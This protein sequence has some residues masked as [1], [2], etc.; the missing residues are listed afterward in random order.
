MR[1]RTLIGLAG[2]AAFAA[3]AI[4]GSATIKPSAASVKTYVLVH[5]AWHGGWC[6]RK[7]KQHLE[8]EGHRVFTPTLSGLGERVHLMSDE[9]GL[10]TH[11]LDVVNHILYE[12]LTD[13]I[14]VG[15]SYGGMVI[16]G[17]V[18]Q[19]KDRISQMVYL[20]AAVPEDGD[21]F[22]SQSPGS[23]TES[24][25]FTENQFR[26]LSEDGTA[27]AVFPA[28]VFGIAASDERNIEWVEKHL[29]PHPLKTWLDHISLQ[30]N[31]SYGVARTYIHCV[32]PI[33][34]NSSFGS[35]YELLSKD[36]SWATFVIQTGHDAMVTAPGR[37]SAMLLA[38]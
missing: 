8:K 29:T 33:L 24:V 30:N 22:A 17:V 6:W 7:V 23:T 20:D 25:E 26:S 38:V 2:A 35:H 19:L 28:S 31:G 5:G 14:L 21:N 15:H 11:I 12:E 37:L 3:P 10:E 9:I 36:E 4:S 16:T 13:I 32:Q 1:R 34:Q 27:M 18:D